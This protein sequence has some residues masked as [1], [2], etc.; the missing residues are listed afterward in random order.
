MGEL[1]FKQMNNVTFRVFLPL[2]LFM[3]IYRA[4]LEEVVSVKLIVFSLASLLV[5][6]L[7]TMYVVPKFEPLNRK[8]GVL[9]QAICRSNFI[10]F[11]LPVATTLYGPESAAQASILLGAVVPFINTLAVITL[12][13]FR[14]TR[15]NPVKIIKSILANP[16]IIGAFLALVLVLTGIKLPRVIDT[17][18][19]EIASL[20]TPIALI[21]LGG[22]VTFSSVKS[23]RIQ[24][25]WGI[26]SRLILVPLVGLGVAI[27]LG[28]R[29]VELVILMAMFSSP[30]AV[31][32]YTMALQMEGDGE[33]AGQLV[34]F[35]TVLS[36][37][38]IFTWVYLLMLFNFI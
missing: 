34:V 3:N 29:N 28:F 23:N 17:F 38:T 5:L 26:T 21:I 27:L 20:A 8:R 7:V 1:S 30:A 24:L 36:I 10:L 12:E 14:G 33:L 25:F 31:S 13:Y 4:D 15:P 35:T 2:L 19:G 37:L 32:S 16:L 9:I 22:S 18:F 6:F 11:G